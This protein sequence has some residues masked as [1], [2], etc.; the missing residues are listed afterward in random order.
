MKNNLVSAGL[1]CLGIFT[2]S[3]LAADLATSAHWDRSS[4]MAAAQSVNIDRAVFEMSTISSLANATVTLEKLEQLET[5][6]DWP[7][8]AK[9]AALFAFT[10]ALAE[11]PRTAVAP[12]VMQHL[13][14]YQART[15]V[16]HEDHADTLVPLYNI[17]G[18]AA[19]VENGWQRNEFAIEGIELLGSNPAGL[20]SAYLDA[21]GRNQRAGY[22]D[23]LRQADVADIAEVQRQA[24]AK[25]DRAPELTP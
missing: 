3:A 23:S 1:F 13:Q 6:S 14:A 4:A 15:L 10:R 5:R 24:L 2:G 22:L 11:L 19:G 20:V 18:A 17:S 25:F 9:E 7:L 8:P 16:P 12:A 21:S